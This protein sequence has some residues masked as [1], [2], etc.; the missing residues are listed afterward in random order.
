LKKI[1]KAHDPAEP[2]KAQIVIEGT[3]E[4]L[5]RSRHGRYAEDANGKEV[6][7][8]EGANVDVTITADAKNM[9]KKSE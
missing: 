5:S 9:I 6:A 8:K 1:I 2:E 3:E 4:T 7:L